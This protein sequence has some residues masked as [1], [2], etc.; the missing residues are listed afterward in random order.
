[1]AAKKKGAYLV[2]EGTQWIIVYQESG[3]EKRLDVGRNRR[4][5]EVYLQRFK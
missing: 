1:M 4:Y 3:K 2:H 5:A